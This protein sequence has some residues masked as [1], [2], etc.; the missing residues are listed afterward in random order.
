MKVTEKS[1]YKVVKNHQENRNQEVKTQINY[2]RV[3]IE[4][5]TKQEVDEEYSWMDSVAGV[6]AARANPRPKNKGKEPARAVDRPIQDKRY[7]AT[8]AIAEKEKDYPT[9]KA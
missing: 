2:I 7:R 5:D 9:I 6:Y 1:S 3:S 8:K 4:S